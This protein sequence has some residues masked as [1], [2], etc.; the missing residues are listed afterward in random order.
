[1]PDNSGR[2]DLSC[3]HAPY[4]RKVEANRGDLGRAQNAE[5]MT[6]DRSVPVDGLNANRRRPA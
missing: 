1:M 2:K 6:A 5:A 3:G 4:N